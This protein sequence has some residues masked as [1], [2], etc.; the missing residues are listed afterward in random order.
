MR[1]DP[2]DPQLFIQNREKLAKRMKPRSVAIIHANDIMP[3][4]ADGTLK[5]VQNSN[6]FWLTGVDQEES[7]ILIAPDFP[8]EKMR[9]ILFLRETNDE[10]AVWEGHKLTKEEGQ[11]AYEAYVQRQQNNG[12]EEGESSSN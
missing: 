6:L 4:N 9:E 10:I 2:I 5:F 8:D 7:I 11:Q 3:S 1:Y 12:T